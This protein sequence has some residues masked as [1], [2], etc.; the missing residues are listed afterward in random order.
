MRPIGKVFRG[1]QRLLKDVVIESQ[2][3]SARATQGFIII[4]GFILL[5]IGRYVWLQVLRHDELATRSEA[6]RV[7]SRPLPCGDHAPVFTPL[8]M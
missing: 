3:F 4:L 7:K 8:G 6:N 1:Q 2:I 5:L